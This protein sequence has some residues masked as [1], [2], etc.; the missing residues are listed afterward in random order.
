MLHQRIR[1]NASEGVYLS[2]P[3]EFAFE[4]RFGQEPGSGAT[5]RGPGNRAQ[6]WSATGEGSQNPSS[7]S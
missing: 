4:L 2:L 3:L 6:S 1:I 5:Q 7:S